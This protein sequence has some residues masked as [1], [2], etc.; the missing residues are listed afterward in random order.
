[1]TRNADGRAEA[2]VPPCVEAELLELVACEAA[3][4]CAAAWLPLPAPDP[5]PPQPATSTAATAAQAADSA[6]TE[7][8]VVAREA[9]DTPGSF[10]QASKAPLSGR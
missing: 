3:A 8:C 4:A 9:A 2:V 10:F 5:A 1:M 7:R 6:A